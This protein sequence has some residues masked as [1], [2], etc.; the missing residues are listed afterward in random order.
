MFFLDNVNANT[1]ETN[2]LS[3]HFS[4]LKFTDGGGVRLPD[5]RLPQ[6]FKFKS[7]RCSRQT[8][9]ADERFNTIVSKDRSLKWDAREVDRIETVRQ[10]F[11]S[12]NRKLKYVLFENEQHL[13]ITT[14]YYFELR[15]IST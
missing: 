2:L 12:V 9:Y 10:Y 6:E 3:Q 11:L 7:W 13:E 14:F 8:I 5:E 1:E 4:K 15:R